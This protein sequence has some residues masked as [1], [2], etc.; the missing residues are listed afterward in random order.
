M[1]AFEGIRNC[2]IVASSDGRNAERTSDVFALTGLPAPSTIR[3][4]FG[5]H[6]QG[7]CFGA[8]IRVSLEQIVRKISLSSNCIKCRLTLF[9]NDF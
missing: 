7:K 8:N 4:N 5:A 2:S 1:K 6:T 3:R 9:L